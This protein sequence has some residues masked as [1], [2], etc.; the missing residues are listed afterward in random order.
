[1]FKISLFTVGGGFAILAVADEVF[2]RRRRWT[3]EGE[4]IDQLSVF[5]M[6]PGIIAGHTAVYI[7][8][9][10]AG[11]AG[12]FCSAAG[13][14]LPSF[15]IFLGVSMGYNLIPVENVYLGAVFSGLRAALAGVIAAMALRCW[16]KNIQGVRGWA[17]FVFAELFLLL[18]VDRNSYP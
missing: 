16:K 10:M 8:N 1:M 9:K 5:Q 6:V 13:A 2:A 4:M 18:K 12:A 14:I 3:R 17:T 11:L 7:G 15:L